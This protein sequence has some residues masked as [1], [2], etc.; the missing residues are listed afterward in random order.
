MKT[1]PESARLVLIRHAVTAWNDAGRFQGHADTPLSEEGRA[2]IPAVIEALRPWQP[3]AVHTSDLSRAREMAEAAARALGLPLTA[4]SALRECSYGSWEG[5]TL[6]EVEDRFPGELEQ[7]R[8]RET[9]YAR[10]GGE[11]LLQMQERTWAA[12]AAIAD[13]HGGETVAVFTHSG[14]VRGA[15]CRLFDLPIEQRYRF[16][17]DNGSLTVL[18]RSGEREWQLVLLNQTSHLDG[19]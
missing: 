17:L 15:V 9:G 10:G 4:D 8:R 3:A 11:S 13:S 5:L 16:A 12:L 14:P 2:M 19:E 6:A 1:P 7:W 18:S